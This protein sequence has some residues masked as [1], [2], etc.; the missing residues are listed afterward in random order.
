MAAQGAPSADRIRRAQR[1]RVAAIMPMA[2]IVAA[3]AGVLVAKLAAQPKPVLALL[4]PLM[5]LPILLW[6]WPRVGV[7]IVMAGAVT[8]EQFTYHITPEK[9]GAVTAKIPL[10]HS[11]SSG[12][13][14]TP[15]EILLF[16]ALVLW[17][18]KSVRDGVRLIPRSP[19][20]LTLGLFLSIVLV[21][22]VY[23]LTHGG[24]YK[25]AIWEIRPWFYLGIMYILVSQL[26]TTQRS[27]RTVLWIFVIGSPIKALYG[28]TIWWSV[29]NIRPRP[30]SM[31]AHEESFFF[32]LYLM[33]V[34]ALWLFGIRGRLRTVATALA[35]IV[36]LGDMM[37]SRRTAWAIL[38]YGV[39]PLLVISYSQLR[40][41][42]KVLLRVMLVGLVLAPVYIPLYWNK[43]G[44]IAQPARAIRSQINPSSR[45]EDS[46]QYRAIENENLQFNIK[47]SRDI[48]EG[49]GVPINYVYALTNLA[50]IDPSIA[51]IPHDGIY[52]IWMR[53]G[54]LGEVLFWIFISTALIRCCR[55]A[56]VANRE[57]AM[58]GALA[59]SA[60]VSYVTMGYLD[61]G[62]FWFRLAF[63]MGIFLGMVEAQL[64][65]H[66]S[67][68]AQLS[69]VPVSRT[70][71][72][73]AVGPRPSIPALEGAYRS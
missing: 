68:S 16:L 30:E 19:L 61:M 49:F 35:P 50:P 60:V 58:L 4:L 67:R 15:A 52:Y 53:T 40:H 20:A 47:S 14:V 73:T 36:L 25:I 28:I 42:R 29:R 62:F 18:M 54:F 34:L 27:V 33:L 46:D 26:M 41:R 69:S 64:Y 5:A 11:V 56:K 51:F 8:I 45:D 57:A 55:L 21:Y 66:R 72:V 1:L 70:P 48:G 9:W 65:V 12:S 22:L 13:G 71:L 43:D 6:K 17:I 23:G 10:F 7:Y 24:H 63:V 59:A 2:V 3:L 39:L 38:G 31:L 32:G 44:T 37:N